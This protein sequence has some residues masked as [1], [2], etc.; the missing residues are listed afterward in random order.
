M[1]ETTVATP[2]GFKQKMSYLTAPGIIIQSQPLE[3][4]IEQVFDIP[5]RSLTD[6]HRLKE[7]IYAK[8]LYRLILERQRRLGGLNGFDL[9]R[10][11]YAR[12]M[13]P[14]LGI[15]F[16]KLTQTFKIQLQRRKKRYAKYNLLTHAEAV[17]CRDS[18]YREL[19]RDADFKFT[20][21]EIATMANTDHATILHSCRTARNLMETDKTYRDKCMEILDKINN[22][23][24]ILP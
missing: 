11:C 13:N 10:Y 21:C 2:A 20:L 4:V 9:K 5:R 18:M 12:A 16:D 8:H 22:H 14:E 1:T 19:T 3:R 7:K 17:R 6:K 24:I 15:Q 23:L